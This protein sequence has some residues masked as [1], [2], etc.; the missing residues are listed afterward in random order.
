MGRS[1]FCIY[2]RYCAFLRFSAVDAG[3]SEIFY[4]LYTA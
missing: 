1:F 2:A 3:K 4:Y